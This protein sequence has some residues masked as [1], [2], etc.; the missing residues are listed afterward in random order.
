M[1]HDPKS[2]LTSICSFKMNPKHIAKNW[3]DEQMNYKQQDSLKGNSPKLRKLEVGI[4]KVLNTGKKQSEKPSRYSWN[5]I[6]QQY[7]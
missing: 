2:H 1:P 4:I 7:S 6:K 5:L 3:K